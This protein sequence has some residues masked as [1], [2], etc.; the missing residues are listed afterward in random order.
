MAHPTDSTRPGQDP[1]D[2][3]V[4]ETFPASDAPSWTP[5]HLGAPPRRPA[6]EQALA[7][8]GPSIV[9]VLVDPEPEY[10]PGRFLG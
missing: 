9:N 2:E 4:D 3:A 8:E 6:L 10:F 7:A 5:T 1:V